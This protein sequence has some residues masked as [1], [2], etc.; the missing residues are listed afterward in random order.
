MKEAQDMVPSQFIRSK[1]PGERTW[2]CLPRKQGTSRLQNLRPRLSI[3][4]RHGAI[5]E[6]TVT[7]CG[8]EPC[9]SSHGMETQTEY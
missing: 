8:S 2:G 7:F 5:A 4:S 9:F 6:V 1:A 3:R